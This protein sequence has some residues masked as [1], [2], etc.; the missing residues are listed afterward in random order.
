MSQT[1]PSAAAFFF[2]LLVPLAS[3]LRAANALPL[4][5]VDPKRESY[6]TDD[7]ALGAHPACRALPK[8][9]AFLIGLELIWLPTGFE[10]ERLVAALHDVM[11][12]LLG[13]RPD[14]AGLQA[15]H[16]IYPLF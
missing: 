3:A 15:G 7:E 16:Q 5:G 10:S 12:A 9:E 4:S 8:R 2:D 6:F 1:D 11:T 14:A 13:S